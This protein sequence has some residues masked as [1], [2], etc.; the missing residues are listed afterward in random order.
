MTVVDEKTAPAIDPAELLGTEDVSDEQWLSLRRDVHCSI[1]L[2]DALAH[3]LASF[4]PVTRRLSSENKAET[5]KGVAL[6]LLGR[7]REALAKLESVRGSRE[8]AM[9]A[10]CA[11]TDL[12]AFER[13]LE[14]LAKARESGDSPQALYLQAELLIKTGK[15]E[16]GRALIGKLPKK[17]DDAPET[18]YLRGLSFDFAGENA[19]ALDHYEKVLELDPAHAKALFRIAFLHDLHGDDARAQEIYES[20][21]KQRPVHVNTIMNLGLIFEDRGEFQKAVACYQ[22]VLDADPNHLRAR[23]YL[24]DAKASLTMYYDEDLARKE[25]KLDQVLGTPLAEFQLSMR[26]QNCLSRLGLRSLGQLIA[27]TEDELLETPNFGQATLKEIKELLA[28]R[29]L[30]LSTTRGAPV[31]ARDLVR[32]QDQAEKEGI[33]GKPITD[34]EWSERIRKS[35]EKLKVQTLGEVVAK[36]EQDF[37]SCENFGQTSLKELKKRLGQMGLSLKT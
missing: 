3:L 17:A 10:A 7:N 21:R 18:H 12:G 20:L 34:F 19:E 4:G 25:Q 31:L 23:L 32:L 24:S 35:F 16:E 27:K 9:I 36:T 8:S 33:L 6:W 37:L 2:H 30:S 15:P 11:A 26:A 22:M 28:A 13:A 1:I 29:G 14:H 5:R